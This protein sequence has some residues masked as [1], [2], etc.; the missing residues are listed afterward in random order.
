MGLTKKDFKELALIVVRIQIGTEILINDLN[1]SNEDKKQEINKMV[2]KEMDEFC[3][4]QNERFN[5]ETFKHFI[6]I[7]GGVVA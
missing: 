5:S 1:K 6:V 3:L 7:N 4:K 2:L